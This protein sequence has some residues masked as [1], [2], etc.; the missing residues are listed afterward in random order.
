M[1]CKQNWFSEFCKIAVKITI[2]KNAFNY[3]LNMLYKGWGTTSSGGQVS[4]KLLEV[5]QDVVSIA[6]CKTVFDN[7]VNFLILKTI[8]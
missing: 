7:S 2:K 6:T 4:N 1:F 5:N 8:V 3:N